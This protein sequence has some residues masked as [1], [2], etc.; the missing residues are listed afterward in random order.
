M[1]ASI[2]YVLVDTAMSLKAVARV[3]LAYERHLD[4]RR[5]Q[6]VAWRRVSL[7]GA[8]KHFYFVCRRC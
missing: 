7:L 6:E 8:G 5:G 1:S 2:R 3:S 4:W